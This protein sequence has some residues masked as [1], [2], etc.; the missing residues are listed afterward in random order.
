M[1]AEPSVDSSPAAAAGS[2]DR[3]AAELRRWTAGTLVGLLWCAA[4]LIGWRW[5]AGA[6]NTSLRPE[7]LVFVGA[8][9]AGTTAGVRI[10]WNRL[11]AEDGSPR[12]DWL[13]ALLPTAAVFALGLALS[14]PKTP[15][16]GNPRAYAVGLVAF[17]LF[18]SAEE[19]WAWKTAPRR[20]RPGGRN[21]RP[22][23]PPGIGV[24]E[25]LS[26]NGPPAVV[27]G[28]VPGD[29]VLQQLTRSQ[30]ADGSDQ[31]S[32]WLRAPFAADQRTATLHLAFCPQ[33]AETPQ[34]T[35]EQLDGPEMTR[36]N[37]A[38]FSFGARLDLKLAAPAEGPLRVLLQFSARSKSPAPPAIARDSTL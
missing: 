35:V 3:P 34:L 15:V 1:T 33:F 7:V 8:L 25:R 23:P 2:F 31:L 36:I 5:L 30:A 9:V 37:K 11:P 26:A 28:E 24:G 20:R 6:L 22:L 29:D 17:W 19:L 16:S 12:V 27:A 4:L 21:A 10:L 13:M 14:W 32:G 18:L 38:V